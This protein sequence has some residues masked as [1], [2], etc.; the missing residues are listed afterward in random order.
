MITCATG[1]LGGPGVVGA[2]VWAET[3]AAQNIK[4]KRVKR[5]RFIEADTLD[6]K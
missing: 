6:D 1:F 4:A 5:M 2:A 3:L